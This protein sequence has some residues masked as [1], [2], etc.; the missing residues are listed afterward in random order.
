[1]DIL[2]S[3]NAKT[4]LDGGISDSDLACD[5]DSATGFPNPTGAQ[6]FYATIQNPSDDTDYEIVKV[7]AVSS[8]TMTIDRAQEG[9]SA[10]AWAT[11]S[12]FELRLTTGGIDALKGHE[13][14]HI[15]GGSA[16]IDGD[17]IDIDFDPDYYT[18][19]SMPGEVSSSATVTGHFYGIDQAVKPATLT[20]TGVVELATTTEAQAGTDTGRAVTPSGLAAAVQQQSWMQAD[21]LYIG[22]DKIRARDSDGL[23]LEDDGGHGL[24]IEDGGDI[25]IDE[26][27]SV[28]GALT[29]TGTTE[30]SGATVA[31]ATITAG[32]GTG[33]T[34]DKAGTLNRQTYQVT[35]DYTALVAAA[36]AMPCS[37]IATL[38]AKTKIVAFYADTTEAYGGGSLSAVTLHVHGSVGGAGTILTFHN[39]S[40]LSGGN[41]LAGELDAHMGSKMTRAAM[42]QGGY[43]PCW[44]DVFHIYANFTLTGDTSN[45]LTSGSTTFYIVTERF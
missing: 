14:D 2:F 33:I 20:S 29:V 24:H 18:P 9:T 13:A 32:S 27:L 30:L 37:L 4:L 41:F 42:E 26:A 43:M 12:L 5:V 6:Y 38:P 1:M 44:D 10:Q 19:A 45:N 8:D 40:S 7:T 36:S 39:V 3:N 21:S 31:S 23:S 34:V 25:S 17:Q 28:T 16:E 22:T 35:M 15:A 11:A